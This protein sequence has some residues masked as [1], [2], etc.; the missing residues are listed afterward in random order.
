MLQ[1]DSAKTLY[2][3]SL[4]CPKNRVDSEVMLG[5]LLDDGYRLVEEPAE[6]E[7]IVINSCA[8]IG[9]AKQE[10]IDA[11]FEHAAYK[12]SGRCRSLV[13]TGCLTQRYAEVLQSE[14][15]EVDHF[16]G[17]G[18]YQHIA[19]II[20]GERDRAVVPD[21]DFV[22][23]ARTPRL[24][25]MP[26]Y[27]AYLKISEGCDNTCS[28][29]IIPTLRGAQRSRPIAD[30]V[31]EA[32]R[33]AERGVVELNLVAQDL[34]AYGHD[35]PG[36]PRLA[37]LLK[38]LARV[39]VQWIRL[40]YAYPRDF[41]DALIDVMASEDRIVKYLDMPLQHASNRMLKAMRRG[42]DRRFIETLLG[43]LRDRIPNLVMRSSFI[44]GFP[45]ETEDDFKELC[46]FVAE[47]KFDRLGAFE[48]S[49]EEGT[50]SYDLEGQ[51]PAR[52][53]ASRRKALMKIQRGISKAHMQAYVG[54]TIPVLVEGPSADT[55][56]L[57][58]GRHAGQAPEIDGSVYINDGVANPG[59]I[60]QVAIEQAGDYDLVGGIV[61]VVAS[62]PVPMPVPRAAARTKEQPVSRKLLNVLP[63]RH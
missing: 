21:P 18:A 17:T 19:Q 35:L 53:K 4:G 26:A 28:F 33:H 22:H 38:E 48:F 24:N 54:R 1:P 42:R 55:E 63:M 37:E 12:E 50:T 32:Q 39:E 52:V 51:L 61:G 16:V 59:D 56:L 5:T 40:H 60:V 29:C 31:A 6:A 8:F 49:R 34:T 43:K 10:S 30:I 14:M 15:P 11:I 27:T 44:V 7:V 45:G 47:Q 57:L 41:S 36:R 23:D 25:S 46:D 13:V 62:A 3:V 58:Q 2:L 9:E 20:R